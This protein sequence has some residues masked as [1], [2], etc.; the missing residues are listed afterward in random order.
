M[1]LSTGYQ[2]ILIPLTPLTSPKFSRKLLHKKR[3]A[4]IIAS[5]Y[6]AIKEEPCD[7]YGSMTVGQ[8]S[9]GRMTNWLMPWAKPVFVRVTFI[10]FTSSQASPQIQYDRCAETYPPAALP[11]SCNDLSSCRDPLPVWPGCRRHKRS[12]SPRFSALV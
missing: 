9:D 7:I 3:I 1:Q 4:H 8:I 10:N 5:K 6:E 12:V 11:E 2:V